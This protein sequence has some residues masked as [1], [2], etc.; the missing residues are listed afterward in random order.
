ML[1][2]NFKFFF[3]SVLTGRGIS[4]EN[5]VIYLWQPSRQAVSFVKILVYIYTGWGGI[6]IKQSHLNF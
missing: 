3:S 1:F 6:Q 4:K 2:L 5:A